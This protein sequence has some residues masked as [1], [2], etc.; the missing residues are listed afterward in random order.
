MIGIT[1]YKDREAV[2][3]SCGKLS[4]LVLPK[5]GAKIASLKA[6]PEGRELLLTRDTPEY[7]RLSYDGIYIDSECSAF[8]DMFP[9]VDPYT[10]SGGAYRGI[11]YPDHGECARLEYDYLIDGDLLILTAESKLFPIRYEKRIRALEN[12][13][14]ISYSYH[15]FG[16]AD[17][18]FIYASHIM[19]KGEDG[20]KILTPFRENS[21]TETV[22]KT[23]GYSDGELSHTELTG[24]IP[25]RGAAY[26]FYYL[27][28]IPNGK[29]SLEYKDGSAI[30]FEYDKEKLPY[31]GIWF[32]NGEFQN[33]YNIA[34]EPCTA[35]FDSPS[36]AEKRGYTVPRL[37]AREKFEFDIDISFLK[38]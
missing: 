30:I 7:R 22:F 18:P 6:M 25:G 33:I 36:E 13:I 19:I 15:N 20:M 32:N 14:R 24:F 34:P 28:K 10:P 23:E 1:S 11:T 27:E 35:P 5:D 2:S 3:V 26:K 17:L 16:D 37:C 29:F 8:D 4:L 12:S 38:E 31:L 9:T 21:E